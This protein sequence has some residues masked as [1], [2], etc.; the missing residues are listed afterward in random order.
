MVFGLFLREIN[1]A[2]RFSQILIEN[3]LV[4]FLLPPT[5]DDGRDPVSDQVRDGPA[6]THEAV[7][8][9]EDSQGLDRYR[10]HHRKCRSERDETCSG[11]AGGS[12]R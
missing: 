11:H 3:V 1:H 5:D 6:L 7:N 4:Q 12:F 2:L 8:A 9:Y 10:R